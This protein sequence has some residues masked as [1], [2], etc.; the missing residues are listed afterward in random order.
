MGEMTLN[1]LT[2]ISFVEYANKLIRQY[3]PKE[4]DFDIVT[5]RFVKK[6]QTKINRRPREELNFSTPTVE[7]FKHFR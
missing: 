3:I 7:F 5:H 2:S 1:D 4:T 6:I